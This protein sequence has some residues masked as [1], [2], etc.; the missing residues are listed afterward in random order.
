MLSDL[1]AVRSLI[2]SDPRAIASIGMMAAATRRDYRSGRRACV[3]MAEQVR[4]VRATA[5]GQMHDRSERCDRSEK[6][7]HR[8]DSSI[9]FDRH[10]GHRT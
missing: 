8:C 7:L 3:T 5:K 10:F 2:A 9:P 1:L 6:R 4:R